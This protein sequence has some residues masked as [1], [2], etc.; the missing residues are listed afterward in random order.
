MKKYV[1][2]ALIVVIL[3]ILDNSIMPLISIGGYYPS[4]L[5]VFLCSYSIINGSFEGL[6]LGVFAG[7]LQDIFFT[8]IFGIN[9]FVNMLIGVLGGYIGRN[10]FKERIIIPSVSIFAMSFIKGVAIVTFLYIFK[11]HVNFFNIIFSSFYN[12]IVSLIIYRKVYKFTNQ[13][14]MKKDWNF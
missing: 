1:Y 7:I 12:M 3:F 14:Y 11:Q 4:L 10:L 2:L 13:D 5:F 8:N 9:A 6:I